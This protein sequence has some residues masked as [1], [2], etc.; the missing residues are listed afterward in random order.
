M[1]KV[2]L[3]SFIL[4]IITILLFYYILKDNFSESIR[5]L[6]SSNLLFV[7]LAFL[8]CLIA[9]LID[10]HIFKTLIRRHNKNYPTKKIYLLSIMTRFF[11]GITPFSLGGQPLQIYELTRNDVKLT[12]SILI[13]TEMYI[14]HVFTITTLSITAFIMKFIFQLHPH[15]FLWTL[16]LIGFSFNIIG[17]SLLTFAALRIKP[18]KKIGKAIIT[19]LSKLHLVKDKEALIDKFYT[20]C[21]EYSKGYKDLLKNKKLIIKCVSLNIFNLSSMFL[22]SYFTI[23]AIDNTINVNI[24]YTYCL[25]ILS[26]ISATFVPIPGSSV[27]AEYTY[28][29]YYKLIIPNNIVVTSLILWRFISYYFPMIIGGIVFNIVDNKRSIKCKEDIKNNT[30]KE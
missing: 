21:V 2:V 9:F 6:S 19:F 30:N 22:I 1:K 18:F 3:R 17:L 16:T 10:T 28:V 27:G 4:L 26:Y 7:L 13:I 12:D 29:N 15:S 20:K 5:L 24:L 25:C 23:K 11:N 14:I 8:M